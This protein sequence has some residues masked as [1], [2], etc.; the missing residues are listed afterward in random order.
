MEYNMN[1]KRNTDEFIRIIKE[2]QKTIKIADIIY[3]K[4]LP[5]QKKL[6]FII[7]IS[8]NELI[9]AYLSNDIDPLSPDKI[10]D[11]FDALLVIS[12]IRERDN[13]VYKTPIKRYEKIAFD[14]CFGDDTSVHT[15]F[16]K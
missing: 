4:L 7:L 15:I 3:L 13:S 16:S 10:G 6:N 11:V 2:N 5:Y 1:K 14:I 8:E 9:K 12:L